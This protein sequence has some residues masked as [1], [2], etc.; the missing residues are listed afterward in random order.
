MA[1]AK[2][3][4]DAI[5]TVVDWIDALQTAPATSSADRKWSDTGDPGS[6]E[7]GVMRLQLT[8]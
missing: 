3:P 8:P 5:G 2:H 1:N 6:R 4:F 7:P